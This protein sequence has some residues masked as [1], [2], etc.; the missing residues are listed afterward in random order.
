MSRGPD[1]SRWTTAELVAQ[2][3]RGDGLAW[4]ELVL[5]HQRLVLG[6]GRSYGLQVADAEDVFQQTFAELAR[7]L[8]RLRNPERLEAWLCTTARRA[9]LR[10]VAAERRH[11]R[12]F[13]EDPAELEQLSPEDVDT[14]IEQ[15]RMAER[16]RRQIEALGPPCSTLL[17]GLFASPPRPYRELAQESG[18]AVGSLGATRAR[19]LDRLRR[20]LRLELAQTAPLAA[21]RP[22]KTR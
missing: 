22:R 21:S 15:L 12:L 18:L 1:R 5:R 6:V 10:L 13:S 20:H 16:V 19:C 14:R 2:C 9:A 11:A 8:G 4:R 17:L 7:S 3:R